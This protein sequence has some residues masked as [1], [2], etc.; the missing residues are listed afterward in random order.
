MMRNR[1][2]C[3]DRSV[4]AFFGMKEFT[5]VGSGLEPSCGASVPS[6][7]LRHC[8][9]RRDLA[10]RA[11]HRRV[12]DGHVDK[13]RAPA[14][15]ET[16]AAQGRDPQADRQ[17]K[18]AGSASSRCRCTSRTAK[19]KVELALAKGKK[20]YDKRHDLAKRDADRE[21][22]QGCGALEQGPSRLAARLLTS[23]SRAGSVRWACPAWSTCTC[24]SCPSR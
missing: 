8:R 6:G 10:A 2:S 21:D 3:V 19:V 14:Q 22:H 23:R 9:R 7:R 1:A 5:S 4:A 16:V 18:E 13:P 17:T 20:S 12:R 11:A 24:T 15:P